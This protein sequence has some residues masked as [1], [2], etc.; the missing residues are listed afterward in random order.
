MKTNRE[1]MD[2][3]C[4]LYYSGIIEADGH[5]ERDRHIS[6]VTWEERNKELNEFR[7]DLWDYFQENDKG[8]RDKLALRL[9][10][11]LEN[12]R[13]NNFFTFTNDSVQLLKMEVE[14]L[15]SDNRKLSEEL[16]WYHKSE[17]RSEQGVSPNAE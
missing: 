12:F 2:E 4:D 14:K 13:G 3:F 1:I 17:K 5:R 16:D 15:K 11:E 9:L 8:K 10:H 6:G 7:G